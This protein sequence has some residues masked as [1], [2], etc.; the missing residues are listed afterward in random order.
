MRR[1][2]RSFGDGLIDEEVKDL[3]EVWMD[4]ADRLLDDEAVVAAI[5]QALVS[6]RS[7]G[8]IREAALAVGAV[9]RPRSSCHF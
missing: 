3:R 2:Q 6:K 4:H 8:A 1:A 9:R 7:A 5:F